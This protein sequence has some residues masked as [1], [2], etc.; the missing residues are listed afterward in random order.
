MKNSISAIGLF[1]LLTACG[2]NQGSGDPGQKT[3]KPAVDQTACPVN[4]DLKSNASAAVSGYL[5]AAKCHLSESDIA[6]R[7]KD[8]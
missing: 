6:E 4:I 7:I 8:N 3:E 5:L 1:I 2:K